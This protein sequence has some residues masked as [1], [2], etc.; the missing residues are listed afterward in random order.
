MRTEDTDPADWRPNEPAFWQYTAEHLRH[1]A[2]LARRSYDALHRD[3]PAP[4]PST[5]LVGG[6]L[7]ESYAYLIALA[8]EYLAIG[9]LMTRDPKHFRPKAPTHRILAL[10]TA[11]GI[12]PTPR[13]VEVLRRIEPALQW[14]GHA[15]LGIA[16]DAVTSDALAQTVPQPSAL[17]PTEVQSLEG[18]YDQLHGLLEPSRARRED[19]GR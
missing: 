3:T 11:C 5:A 6:K 18:L 2:D 15:T 19:A 10:L 13:Q 1:V 17:A 8:L 12:E 7:A 9:V 4:D 16:P 14:S